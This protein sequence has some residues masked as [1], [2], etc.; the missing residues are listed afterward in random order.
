MA[1]LIM[2]CGSHLN[3]YGRLTLFRKML[4]SI[5]NQQFQ[6]P[7]FVSVSVMNQELETEVLRIAK[8]YPNF[9]FFIQDIQFTQFE[10][11][12]FLAEALSYDPTT[13]WCMFT[14]DDDISNF[15]RTEVFMDHIKSVTDDI[16]VVRDTSVRTKYTNHLETKCVDD[17][18][19]DAI[20]QDFI[21]PT[22]EYIVNACKLAILQEFCRKAS[23]STILTM[24]GCDMIF[25]VW[26]LWNKTKTF[27]SDNW[28][29]EYT[30]RPNTSR[31]IA[32][33]EASLLL[34]VD[35]SVF[36]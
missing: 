31:S 14:D 33:T 34:K 11:Y 23:K 18:S 7:L 10:H 9:T 1:S 28:L 26:V 12:A 29:Y 21:K 8:E 25:Q 2:L 20:I 4:N 6:V 3:G 27:H 15:N 17:E 19:D 5:D 30:I 13:T 22:N 35:F 24:T 32:S 16:E 36:D